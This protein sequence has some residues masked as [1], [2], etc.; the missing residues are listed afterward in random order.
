MNMDIQETL[1]STRRKQPSQVFLVILIATILN[2]SFTGFIFM[3]CKIHSAK[4]ECELNHIS[5]RL[6]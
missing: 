3:A 6:K 4:T 5:S 1:Q 2:L